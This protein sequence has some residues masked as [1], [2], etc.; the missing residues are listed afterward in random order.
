MSSCLW[1]RDSSRTEREIHGPVHSSRNSNVS[2]DGIPGR[3]GSRAHGARR[4]AI[5]YPARAILGGASYHG[6]LTS[7]R[8]SP[9]IENELRLELGLLS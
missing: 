7:P 6:R 3:N 4:A 2:C 9:M 8:P 1:W 5:R